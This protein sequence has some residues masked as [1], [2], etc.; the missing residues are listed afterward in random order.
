MY[1]CIQI[2]AKTVW[3]LNSLVISYSMILLSYDEYYCFGG[4]LQILLKCKLQND[5]SKY[6]NPECTA[7]GGFIHIH[8]SSH[9][10]FRL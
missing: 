9:L 4:L 2:I 1:A 8:I 7:I 5:I 6:E 3:L 10:L